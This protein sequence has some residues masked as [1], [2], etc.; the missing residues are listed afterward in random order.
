M[1][2]LAEMKLVHSLEMVKDRRQSQEVIRVQ[3]KLAVLKVS[4]HYG[5]GPYCTH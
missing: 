4:R 1:K 5:L 2:G 3:Y